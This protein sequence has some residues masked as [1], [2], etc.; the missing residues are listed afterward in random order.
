MIHISFLK[1]DSLH[2]LSKP[3]C[4]TAVYEFHE[5]MLH[6][7]KS[8]VNTW[9]PY[10]IPLRTLCHICLSVFLL[11]SPSICL[12]LFLSFSL[13][14]SVCHPFMHVMPYLSVFSLVCPSNCLSLF[15]SFSFCPSVC[16]LFRHVM[17][18]FSAC[19]SLYFLF[20]SICLFIQLS[21]YHYIIPYQTVSPLL[22]SLSLSS[23]V[24]LFIQMSSAFNVKP[25]CLLISPN[26]VGICFDNVC[27]LFFL[28]SKTPTRQNLPNSKFFHTFVQ[29]YLGD[30]LNV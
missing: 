12:P 27:L 2:P 15:L 4:K 16:H 25:P 21:V 18:T 9:K 6:F 10:A 5:C 8:H 23:F 13:S 30:S 7:L 19:L 17:P 26:F 14:L 29:D 3:W 11:V 28:L 20:L 24:C 1:R 22:N